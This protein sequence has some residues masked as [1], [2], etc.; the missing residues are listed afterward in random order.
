MC[1]LAFVFGQNLISSPL[2]LYSDIGLDST[3]ESCNVKVGPSI[4]A[5][6]GLYALLVQDWGVGGIRAFS[7]TEDEADLAASS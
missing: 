7:H 5:T 1:C 3:D 2:N 4:G 6:Y